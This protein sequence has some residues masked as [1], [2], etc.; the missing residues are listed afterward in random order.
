MSGGKTLSGH[1]RWMRLGMQ[2]NLFPAYE[3][4]R[5]KVIELSGITASSTVLDFGCG[6]GL[7]EEYIKSS[8]RL[9]DGKVTGVDSGKELIEIAKSGFHGD[10]NFEFILTDEG[11][12]LPFA[13]DSFDIILS[14]LVFHLLNS[15]QKANVL[16][17]FSRV[18]KPD[19]HMLLAEIG[20]PD[21]LF[22]RYIKLVTQKVWVKVWPYE[23]NSTDSFNGLLKDFIARAG[24]GEIR[25]VF[26][27]KGYIDFIYV[28]K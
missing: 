5:R 13:D 26:R 15:D 10:K 17:E 7:L 22:G 18:L 11:G 16:K 4:F 19:G 25:T 24:F 1:A 23:A 20:K 28:R 6:V 14:N 8:V 2:A 12:N 21:T 9:T 27:M 3:R